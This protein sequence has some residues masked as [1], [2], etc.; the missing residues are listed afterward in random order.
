MGYLNFS[1]LVHMTF[2]LF[3]E[4]QQ[5]PFEHRAIPCRRI[6]VSTNKLKE[7]VD[8]KIKQWNCR[9]GFSPLCE[10]FRKSCKQRQVWL[11]DLSNSGELRRVKST[12]NLPE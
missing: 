2:I 1:E 12:S 10:N 7:S 5:F 3:I 8:L 4:M 9:E 6:W 11:R